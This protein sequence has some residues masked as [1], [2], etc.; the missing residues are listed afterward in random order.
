MPTIL[1]TDTKGIQSLDCDPFKQKKI[2]FEGAFLKIIMGSQVLDTVDLSSFFH[3]SL[4]CGGSFKKKVYVAANSNYKLYGGNIAQDQGEV[5]LIIVRVKYDKSLTE[6]EKL[7]TVSYKGS[8]FS[9]KNIMFLT[10]KTL[11]NE[12]YQGWDLEPFGSHTGNESTPI[13]SP[14]PTSPDFQEGGMIINNLTN[15]EIELEILVMN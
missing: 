1:T 13:L 15:K 4:D 14:M 8:T 5:S 3:P 6:G 11:P 12:K 10:G 7:I 9:I 2:V